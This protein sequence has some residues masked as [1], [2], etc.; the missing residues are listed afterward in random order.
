MSA[1]ASENDDVFSH[2]TE[3][4]Q[5]NVKNPTTPITRTFSLILAE[6]F[7]WF[8]HAQMKKSPIRQTSHHLFRHLID[9]C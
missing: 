1:K 6:I 8:S 4:Q 5:D 9:Y 3:K 7:H 2:H